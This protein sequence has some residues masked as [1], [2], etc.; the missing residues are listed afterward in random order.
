[1]VA[2]QEI[3][4]LESGILKPVDGR[5]LS[6]SDLR[7]MTDFDAVLDGLR[8]TDADVLMAQDYVGSGGE[9]LKDK[10]RLVGV[11][12]II[13]QWSFNESDDFEDNIFVSCQILT[14]HRERFVINDGTKGGIRDQLL[15]I[16]SET[17]RFNY[18]VCERGL[19]VSEYTVEDEDGKTKK[20]KS[21]YLS[22]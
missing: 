16:S 5:V 17:G 15:S 7:E 19:V 13:L 18:M 3:E 22:S 9:L 14:K 10:D 2:R 11:P 20:A 12:F 6:D 21:Y 1:M 8:D 4:R